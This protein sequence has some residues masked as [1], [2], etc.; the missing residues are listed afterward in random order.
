MGGVGCSPIPSESARPS[1]GWSVSAPFGKLS[2]RSNGLSVCAMHERVNR[3]VGIWAWYVAPSMA[4]QIAKALPN[5][6]P[7]GR[8][9]G[10]AFALLLP[11]G[12]EVNRHCSTSFDI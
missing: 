9:C 8:R 3:Y 12:L 6:P 10:S 4:R 5:C 11:F 2:R 7:I 1:E